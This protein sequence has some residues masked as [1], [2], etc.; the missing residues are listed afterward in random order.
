MAAMSLHHSL[1]QLLVL[2]AIAQ[3]GSFAAAAEALHRVPSAVSYA[4]RTLEE[5]LGVPLFDRS[6]H[7]A[8]LT[9][10]GRRLLEAGQEVLASARAFEGLA[11][12]LRDEWEPELQ[13]VVDGVFPMGPVTR[14]LSVFTQRELPTRVRLDLEY[15]EGVPDRWQADDAD[16]MLI[17]DFD[18]EGDPLEI[19]PLP[20]LEMLLVAAPSHPLMQQAAVE[21]AA[22]RQHFELVVKDS[23]PRYAETPKRPYLGSQHVIYL[24]DFHSKRLGVLSGL[25]FGWL[26]RHLIEA[27]LEAGALRP[28]DRAEGHSW[29]YH[30]QLVWRADRPLGRAGRLFVDALRQELNLQKS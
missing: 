19:L 25:G 6:G 12:A 13:V 1:D 22:L 3:H 7:R 20:P 5:Q 26:P 27:D 17:L 23:S 21:E 2:E 8:R 10:E 16:L 15:Q 24:S 14:A 28:L 4:V 18:P 29:T 9:P 11:Q 30:P